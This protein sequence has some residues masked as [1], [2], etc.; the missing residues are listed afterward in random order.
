[1]YGHNAGCHP[2]NILSTTVLVIVVEKHNHELVQMTQYCSLT[3]NDCISRGY[4]WYYP[5]HHTC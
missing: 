4:S 3:S 5:L 1:M 2:Y